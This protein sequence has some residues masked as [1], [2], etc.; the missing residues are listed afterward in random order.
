MKDGEDDE[1]NLNLSLFRTNSEC[2]QSTCSRALG[3][4]HILE[5]TVA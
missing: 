5:H 3:I 2:R 4:H 1:N